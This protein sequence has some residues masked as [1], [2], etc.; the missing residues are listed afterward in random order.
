[1]IDRQSPLSI[2]RQCQLLGLARV[3]VYRAPTPPS[4]TKL[5]LMKRID[6]LHCGLN[7]MTSFHPIGCCLN[8]TKITPDLGGSLSVSTRLHKNYTKPLRNYW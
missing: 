8:Y 4:A 7:R 5:D 1:M 6:K 2:V 3:R